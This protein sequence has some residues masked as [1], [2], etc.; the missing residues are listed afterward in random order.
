[1]YEFSVQ[2][3]WVNCLVFYSMLLFPQVLEAFPWSKTLIYLFLVI[4]F[5]DLIK[6]E[7]WVL[8]SPNGKNGSV[9]AQGC[10]NNIYI[11]AS[12]LT[13]NLQDG[14]DSSMNWHKNNKLSSWA[15]LHGWIN[16][17]KILGS[18]KMEP[19]F[20]KIIVWSTVVF[21][22]VSNILNFDIVQSRDRTSFLSSPSLTNTIYYFLYFQCLSYRFLNKR[23]KE[24]HR[25]T[26]DKL[27][28]NR[29]TKSK[30]WTTFSWKNWLL[31]A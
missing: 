23:N 8:A 11:T 19:L 18:D 3:Y 22:L 21:H 4:M 20:Q 9:W 10:R 13:E 31:M 25:P 26:L 7:S 5:Y 17:D 15:I 29:P 2:L 1:M 30:G 27:T 14:T 16:K 6:L 12:I 28:H 24:S